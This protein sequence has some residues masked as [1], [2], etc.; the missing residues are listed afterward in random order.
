MKETDR[1]K[2]INETRNH[3]TPVFFCGLSCII[4]GGIGRIQTT[5]FYKVKFLYNLG[6]TKMETYSIYLGWTTYFFEVE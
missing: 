5:S 2:C 4:N 1:N 3:Q 6:Q